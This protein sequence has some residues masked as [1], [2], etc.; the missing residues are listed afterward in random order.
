M[1]GSIKYALKED[2]I[3]QKSQKL[4]DIM[5]EESTSHQRIMHIRDA[6]ERERVWRENE[7]FA[8][9]SSI[10]EVLNAIDGLLLNANS[11]GRYVVNNN[12]T[13]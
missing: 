3:Q 1:V 2:L 4:I 10:M 13:S 12:E 6:F 8:S 5:Q 9:V 7:E 11:T